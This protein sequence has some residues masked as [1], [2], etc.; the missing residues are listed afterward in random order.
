LFVIPLL[1]FVIPEGNLLFARATTVYAITQ[2]ALRTQSEKNQC[3][4]ETVH[5]FV[6]LRLFV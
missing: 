5:Y 2:N 1:L 6:L 4:V 3:E